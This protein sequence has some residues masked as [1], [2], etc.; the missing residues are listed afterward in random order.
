MENYVLYSFDI[1]DTLI[2]RNTATPAGIFLLTQKDIKKNKELSQILPNFFIDNFVEI[3][4][5]AERTAAIEGKKEG[6]VSIDINYI[7]NVMGKIFDINS[8][9]MDKIRQLEIKREKQL[10][11]PITENV[12][13]LKEII[14]SGKRVVLISDMYLH[15]TDIRDMLLQHDN[16]FRNIT[17]YVSCEC[18]KLK[19]DGKLFAYVKKMENIE[20]CRWQ[21]MGDNN[22][23]DVINAKKYGIN[24][25]QYEYVN[26]PNR[27]KKILNERDLGEQLIFG[28][29]KNARLK[30]I[31]TEGY[32]W[33]TYIGASIL[34]PYVL[35][36]LGECIQN[37]IN[38]L[39]FVARD[40]FI[41]KKIADEIIREYDFNIVT[42]YIYGSRKAWRLS[43]DRPENVLKI[44]SLIA[45][46]KAELIRLY[47]EQE[48]KDIDTDFAFVDVQ[49]TGL[50]EE[51]LSKILDNNKITT[52]FLHKISNNYNTNNSNR[53]YMVHTINEISVIEL[54]TRAPHG[55]V[56]GYLKNDENKIVPV[57]DDLSETCKE[58]YDK[59]YE[60]G[61]ME[62][63]TFILNNSYNLLNRA[64]LWKVS[65]KYL[66][67]LLEYPDKE[68]ADY[69]GEINFEKTIDG[70][71]EYVKFAPKLSVKDMKS[72][73]L[74]HDFSMK[75]WKGCSIK[76]SELRNSKDV[77]RMREHYKKIDKNLWGSLERIGHFGLGQIKKELGKNKSKDNQ[78]TYEV[79]STD[80]KNKI[81][82]YGA[83]KVGKDI[84][85]QVRKYKKIELV[86]WFDKNSQAYQ[87]IGMKVRNIEEI[88]KEDFEQIIICVKDESIADNIK[89]NLISIGIPNDKIYWND[90]T[91]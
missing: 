17:I 13:K 32:T 10:S 68:S 88:K 52:F 48:L 35:W 34:I 73:Y 78:R 28:A 71:D 80:L 47:I 46:E 42:Y 61:V 11:I 86:G 6:I 4:I 81:A 43:N 20:Y 27:V 23:S 8:D 58:K 9:L 3:R 22:I 50:T 84:Y 29:E 56:T 70:K 91:K 60:K 2:T 14:K 44:E 59:E 30:S 21:H 82:L 51:W 24:A 65:Q 79:C 39:F 33:G 12:K 36:I 31:M 74:F 26:L 53:S 37:N 64:N 72:I 40:G 49:G 63:L 41:V 38:H 85:D 54:L 18:N 25:I 15:E 62:V 66:I 89:K 7:Y 75:E 69:F 1:F 90:Y 76:Y 16:I 5:E 87:E 57:F 55:R 19:S 77:D 45:S 67:D 83:G